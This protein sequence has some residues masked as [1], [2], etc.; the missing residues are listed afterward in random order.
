MP[1]TLLHVVGSYFNHAHFLNPTF[2]ETNLLYQERKSTP[3]FQT[4][5][6]LSLFD[7]LVPTKEDTIKCISGN[8]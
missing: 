2:I 6:Q 8:L 1:F 4:A 5:K 7:T 3:I